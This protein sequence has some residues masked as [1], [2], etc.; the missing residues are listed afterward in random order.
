MK[1]LLLLACIFISGCYDS[2]EPAFSKEKLRS[3]VI[4]KNISRI[5]R[6]EY[7]W[8][9]VF[10]E[11]DGA[12][13]TLELRSTI[14]QLNFNQAGDWNFI[15]EYKEKYPEE[16]KGQ[17]VLIPDV[18]EGDMCWAKESTYDTS[19]TDRDVVK[20]S[21]KIELHIHST[22]DINAEGYTYQ[23][24]VRKHWKTFTVHSDVIE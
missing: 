8:Y 11:E 17:F 16:I 24:K 7:N 12:I 2:P 13:E 18:K 15:D 19:T 22:K 21:V 20:E 6:H 9:T 14:P 3:V 23:K 4:H 10:L 1:Y 5:I